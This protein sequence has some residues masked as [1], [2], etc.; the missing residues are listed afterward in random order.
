MRVGGIVG[1]SGGDGCVCVCEGMGQYGRRHAS[2]AGGHVSSR[3]FSP[4]T[5]FYK[6]KQLSHI[7]SIHTGWQ[8]KTEVVVEGRTNAKKR[9]VGKVKGRPEGNAKKRTVGKVKGTP[10]GNAEDR[11][12]AIMPFMGD[13]KTTEL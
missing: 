13:S 9:T 11:T 12:L 5:F 8:G 6:K 7:T 10:E 4:S 2:N 1:G 3:S